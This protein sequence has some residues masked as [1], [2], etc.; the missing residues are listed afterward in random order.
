MHIIKV[1]KYTGNVLIREMNESEK[2]LFITEMNSH[3][4][5]TIINFPYSE[6]L[7]ETIKSQFISEEMKKKSPLD[8][9]DYAFG[10]INNF[11]LNYIDYIDTH[12][13]SL[14][15]Y[16]PYE[17][18]RG[19][20]LFGGDG[21]KEKTICLYLKENTTDDYLFAQLNDENLDKYEYYKTTN[22]TTNNMVSKSTS[23]TLTIGS[24]P[25]GYKPIEEF[26]QQLTCIKPLNDYY[27]TDSPKQPEDTRLTCVSQYEKDFYGETTR[28]L[29]HR[30]NTINIVRNGARIGTILLGPPSQSSGGNSQKD[31]FT[32]LHIQN[33]LC[34][35]PYSSQQ[36][37]S[38]IYMGVQKNKHSFY[39][40]KHKLKGLI[41]LCDYNR[42]NFANKL[43]DKMGENINPQSPVEEPES[44]KKNKQSKLP[45]EEPEVLV[46]EPEVLVE[47]PE[48]PVEE[49]QSPVEEPESPVEEPQSPVEEPQPPVEEPQ[50]PVEEPQSPVEEPEV[51]VEEPEVPVEEPQPPVEEPELSIEE[52]I[53]PVEENKQSLMQDFSINSPKK[54]DPYEQTKPMTKKQGLMFVKYV[55]ENFNT[56][57]IN[58]MIKNANNSDF[59]T[60]LGKATS[61]YHDVLFN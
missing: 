41:R 61:I 48:V 42:N 16:N 6:T 60:G 22:K 17:L 37:P 32:K 33:E 3:K 35:Y 56:S 43:W 1:K 57:Q 55:L 12:D 24:L 25:R 47:E 19:R 5:G 54:I 10:K 21:K 4:S 34:Y 45:V 49:P 20:F 26:T 39:A 30:N 38:D 14:K 9:I 28:N 2:Q 52:L 44:P 59:V 36:N 11:K 15:M 27:N 46:E 58:E 13:I 40:D 23:T 51:P 31:K 50:S 18:E 29:E 7:H 8:R 53:A